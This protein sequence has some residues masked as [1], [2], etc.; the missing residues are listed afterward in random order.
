M[1]RKQKRWEKGQSIFHKDDREH[2][3]MENAYGRLEYIRENSRQPDAKN[4]FL[5]KAKEAPGTPGHTQKE[6][7]LD[8]KQVK[9]ADFQEERFLFTNEKPFRDQAVFYD[10][11][12]WKRSRDFMACMK[13]LLDEQGHQTLRDTFGFLEQRQ[14]RILRQMLE[15]ERMQN[16]SLE[17]FDL[18]NKQI[19]TLNTCIQKKEAKERQLCAELQLMIDRGKEKAVQNPKG[20]GPSV[21]YLMQEA[22]RS[23][24][25]DSGEEETT[26]A[27]TDAVEENL[28]KE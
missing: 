12:K 7:D 13:S 21:N 5:V 16:L 15:E 23:K 28:A 19:D 10:I 2:F 20:L 4:G 26:Q 24:E 22:V 1:E 17:E 8:P 3:Q 27:A 18:V 11:R 14:D 6:K 9:D 25:E